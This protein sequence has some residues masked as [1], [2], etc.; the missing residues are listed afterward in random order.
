[1][2]P[3][4]KI[5]SLSTFFDTRRGE[6]RAVDDVSLQVDVGDTLGIVGE[7]GC[8]KTVLSLSIMKLVPTPPGK[9]VGGKI[10]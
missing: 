8:G 2:A 6:V 5:E 10:L 7:S 1:M 3:V 9:Y 4:L